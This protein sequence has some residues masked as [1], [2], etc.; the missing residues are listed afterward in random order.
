MKSL[1]ILAAAVLFVSLGALE[2]AAQGPQ[3]TG[4]AEAAQSSS[5]PQS[6]NPIKWIKKDPHTETASL[7]AS[8]TQ[9]VK[10]SSRLQSQ[11]LLP[12]NAN[13]K[14]TCSTIKELSDCVA[15]LHAGS[16]LGLDFGCLKSKLSG[17]QAN[18]ATA[19]SCASATDGKP[20][21][22]SKAIHSLMPKANAAAE[23]K[24]AEAQSRD[25]FRDA[26]SGT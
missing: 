23:A 13:L 14:E 4:A 3:G 11:G 7:D 22:L 12:A 15:A 10:L 9:N 16:N 6:F 17:V 1:S 20:L 25:D 18:M 2:A 24:R 21:S 5:G 19:S 26:G 8:S